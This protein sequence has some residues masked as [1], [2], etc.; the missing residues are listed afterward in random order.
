[1][2]KKKQVAKLRIMEESSRKLILVEEDYY[3]NQNVDK[4]AEY[5]VKRLRKKLSSEL[6]NMLIEQMLGF[7]EWMQQEMAYDFELFIREHEVRTTGC[8]SVDYV[9]DVCYTWIAAELKELKPNN[10]KKKGKPKY[11]EPLRYRN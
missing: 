9:L 6:V 5:L 2:K 4:S 3:D 7:N 10:K 8:P 1:M 11:E